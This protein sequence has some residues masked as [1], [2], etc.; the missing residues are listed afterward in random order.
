MIPQCIPITNRDRD[1]L[2]IE[3]GV[4]DLGKAV[5]H[6]HQMIYLIK[7]T[8]QSCI[9]VKVLIGPRHSIVFNFPRI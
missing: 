5:L 6:E 9:A 3:V 8:H 1:V 2:I 4:I 7:A